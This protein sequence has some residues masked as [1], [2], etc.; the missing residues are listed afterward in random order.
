MAD[1]KVVDKSLANHPA[2][3]DIN[4]AGMLNLLV[5]YFVW[6]STY[7]AIR[8]AVREGAGFPPFTMGF[9]RTAAGGVLLLIWGALARKRLRPTK[10][11]LLTLVLSGIFLWN[12]GNG[13]VMVAEQRADSSLAALMI[14]STPI[15]VA[16]I[17]A[18]LDRR[19]PSWLLVGA[20]LVGFSGIAVLSA[21]VLRNGV[22]ADMLS[23]LALLGAAL[24][25]SLGT[26]LQ[27]RRPVDLSAQVSSGIQTLAGAVGFAGLTLLF[28]EPLPTPNTEAWLAWGYL[29]V[30]G[31]VLAFTA[32]VTSLRL[33]P[34][35]IVVT[36]SYVNPVIA[37]ILGWIILREPITAW[38][39]TG[40]ALVLLGVWGVFRSRRRQREQAIAAKAT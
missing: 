27:S 17:E 20:L 38:T 3:K 9:M 19:P 14:A 10:S 36:Y 25:W 7:L 34:T 4:L 33:L 23:I 35:N 16:I 12:G 39:I 5:V 24:S 1:S 29:V 18:I 40:S 22:R 2:E 30:F 15:W 21:P 8:M 32:Y 37:V 11:E 13:L 6:G 28:G 31:S 26:V